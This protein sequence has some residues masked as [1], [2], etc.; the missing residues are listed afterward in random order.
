M[1]AQNMDAT[2]SG[3]FGPLQTLVD[4]PRC[5]RIDVNGPGTGRVFSVR[6]GRHQ[7]EP[8]IAFSS[9]EVIRALVERVGGRSTSGLQELT[10]QLP[11]DGV[12]HATLPPLTEHVV[13][14]L[15]RP[16]PRPA[17]WEQLDAMGALP[18]ELGAILTDMLRSES[19]IV[20][21]GQPQSGTTTLLNVLAGALP[22]G[23]ATALVDEPRELTIAHLPG[24]FRVKPSPEHGDT[25]DQRALVRQAL[26][27][28]PDWLVLNAALPED[29]PDLLRLMSAGRPR[30]LVSMTISQPP[31]ETDDL[32][33]VLAMFASIGEA[34][35]APA[36][37]LL[38]D[39]SPLLVQTR[40]LPAR[41]ET[42][43]R[44]ERILSLTGVRG[45]KLT[46]RTIWTALP[47]TAGVS[48]LRIA[49]PARSPDADIPTLPPLERGAEADP[50]RW[51]WAGIPTGVA[52]QNPLAGGRGVTALLRAW[53]QPDRPFAN[54]P[55]GGPCP[56]CAELD[57][58]LAPTPAGDSPAVRAVQYRRAL[59]RGLH[60]YVS[61]AL[62]PQR[63]HSGPTTVD[64]PR[65]PTWDREDGRPI[66]RV[67]R[68]SEAD[69]VP[70]AFVLHRH[71][72]GAFAAA[73]LRDLQDGNPRLRFYDDRDQVF[74]LP[75]VAGG[76][77]G[78]GPRT[79]VWL[80][81]MADFPDAVTGGDEFSEIERLVFTQRWFSL[82]RP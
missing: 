8:E 23:A 74:E 80:L 40:R 31:R 18:L 59:H 49:A 78:Q 9:D 6:A 45:G 16:A 14:T 27:A 48:W 12:L 38:A 63:V 52:G 17:H 69:F 56:T 30:C 10:V 35:Q 26:A 71:H 44:L 1:D 65:D 33:E 81:R 68:V 4:D 76:Y 67:P 54:V 75:G 19:G 50:D 24:R 66:L 28:N 64:T 73:T 79:T 77:R 43:W 41:G 53:I 70:A 62:D 36:L 25:D 58:L 2:G 32:L 15:S 46:A 51:T 37:A 11:G 34:G 21:I 39:A 22:A 3:R 60:M 82:R 7:Q 5:G 42:P 47:D 61:A 72:F 55:P 20:I 57:A 29:L 13:L